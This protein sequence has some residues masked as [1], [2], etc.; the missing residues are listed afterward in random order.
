MVLKIALILFF[1]FFITFSPFSVLFSFPFL[2]LDPFSARV[3][4]LDKFE[5]SFHMTGEL[6]DS[7]LYIHLANEAIIQV[8][9]YLYPNSTTNITLRLEPTTEWNVTH[10][11][12]GIG[13]EINITVTNGIVLDPYP[14]EIP[15]HLELFIQMENE[16]DQVWGVYN[17]LVVDQGWDDRVRANWTFI[18]SIMALLLIYSKRSRT[19]K[20]SKK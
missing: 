8:Y 9:C 14:S 10:V 7:I 4:S 1:I 12:I 3:Q 20:T 13:Q 19:S 18:P 5:G 2:Y 11:D 15:A 6:E 16:T 17:V